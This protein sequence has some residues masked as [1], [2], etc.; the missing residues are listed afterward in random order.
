MYIGRRQRARYATS[1]ERRDDIL[2]WSEDLWTAAT[3]AMTVVYVIEIGCGER[4]CMTLSTTDAEYMAL[5]QAAKDL[6]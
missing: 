5:C 6:V 4:P 3:V 2:L 1:G